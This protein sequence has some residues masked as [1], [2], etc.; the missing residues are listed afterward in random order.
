M[1]IMTRTPKAAATVAAFAFLLAGCGGKGD[2]GA[3]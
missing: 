2:A 1:H 3:A